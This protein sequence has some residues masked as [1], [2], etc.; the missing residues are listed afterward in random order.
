VGFEQ[1]P[2]Q[3]LGKWAMAA[4]FEA[5]TFLRSLQKMGG[6]DRAG[7]HFQAWKYVL[8]LKLA[9]AMAPCVLFA[10]EIEKALARASSS[11]QTDSGV[12]ARVFFIDLPGA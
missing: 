8:A 5:S 12:T 11:G 7:T 3:L 4:C 1:E 6:G 9:D 2:D 10:D